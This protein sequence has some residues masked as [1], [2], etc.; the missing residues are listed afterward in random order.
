[1]ICIFLVL[2]FIALMIMERDRRGMMKKCLN[3]A[4]YSLL[5]GGTRRFSP[6][7]GSCR[8][9]HDRLRRHQLS[10]NPH[11]LFF[12]RGNAGE[13]FCQCGET[14]IGLDHWPNIYCGVGVLILLPLYMMNRRIP[15]REK[16][17][18]GVL[19]LVMLLGFSLNIPNFIWHGFHYPNS[20]P[21]RQSFLYIALLL[22]MC[23]EAYK[24]IRA[25]TAA[26]LAGSFWGAVI[27]IFACELMIDNGTMD[28]RSYYLTLLFVGIY[29]LLLYYYRNRKAWK[30]TLA[31]LAIMV[32][33]IESSMNTAV[34]SVTTTSR[35]AYLENQDS[36]R[37][38]GGIYRT[39]G[40]Q[41]VPHRKGFP[42]DQK[43][44]RS[45]RLPVRLPV[46]LY[47]Q[48]EPEQFL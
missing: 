45:G 16:A 3:F 26:Q 1:M 19:L 46:F 7:S 42:E 29:A 31:I 48:R 24:N 18:K 12:L 4:V 30:P 21:A 20:L 43:R 33:A 9:V 22:T 11:L 25:N 40:Q 38:A 23:F 2:Y 39:G 10:P 15:R 36:Y 32:I 27:F 13:T 47:S 41:S 37:G 5:A 14:E 8:A 35:T 17:A 6:A 44:R 28:F 34:T